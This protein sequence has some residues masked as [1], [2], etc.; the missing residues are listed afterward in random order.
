MTALLFNSPDPAAQAY[1]DVWT[2]PAPAGFAF[3]DAPGQRWVKVTSLRVYGIPKGQPRPRAFARQ[4]GNKFVAR[5]YDAGT[6]EAWKGEIAAAAGKEFDVLLDCPLRVCITFLFPRPKC[7]MRRK[8]PEGRVP[9][10]AKPDVDNLSK[11]V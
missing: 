1:R 7:L 5:V 8:D 3:K 4:M 11:A 9:H 2:N 10:T 6:S